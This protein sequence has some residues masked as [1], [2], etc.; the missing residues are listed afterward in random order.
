[1]GQLKECPS[2]CEQINARAIRCPRCHSWQSKWRF[3]QSNIKHQVIFLAL[4]FGFMAIVFSSLFGSIFNPKDFSESKSLLE[5][6]NS[7]VSYST[8]DCGPSITVICTISNNSDIAWKD[9]NFEA[10]FYNE[11]NDLIDTVSD[12]NYDLLLLANDEST[13]KITGSADKP[14]ALYHHHKVIIKDAR[15]NSSLF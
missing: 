1:M 8:K 14:E 15:E 9:F 2:C 10:Q 11:N 4:I 3:D 5:I 6:K 13:F 12:Q 7:K